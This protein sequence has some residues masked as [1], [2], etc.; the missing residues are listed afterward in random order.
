M[1]EAADTADA[2]LSGYP[3][4]ELEDIQAC[5][6]DAKRLVGYERV[7]PLFIEPSLIRILLDTCVWGGVRQDLVGAGLDV[8]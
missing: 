6:L 4:V 2:I 8:L 1:P 7:E 3:C 5:L